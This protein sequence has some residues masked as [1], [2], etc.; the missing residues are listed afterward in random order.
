MVR[1]FALKPYDFAFDLSASDRAKVLLL[2]SAS[3]IRATNDQV[4][5][6]GWKRIIF[7]RLSHFNWSRE[8]QVVRD[9][10]TVTDVMG[11][12]GEPG[13]LVLETHATLEEVRQ[14]VPNL[15]CDRPWAIIHA[16]TRWAYKQWLPERWAEV[17][18]ALAERYGMRV[19]FSCGPDPR[20]VAHVR[21]ILQHSHGLHHS[22]EGQLSLREQARLTRAAKLL[23]CVDT[24]AAHMGAAVQTPTV[25]L[26]AKAK[27][28]AWGPWRCPSVCL[29][30]DCSCRRLGHMA[31]TRDQPYKCVAGI[32]T[33]AVLSAA[34]QLL[35][36]PETTSTFAARV[37]HEA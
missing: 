9:F 15:T 17:A 20:E 23:L 3:R 36:Q 7:N 6:L 1:E 35:R 27:P 12:T 4:Y 11:Q 10:R 21:K 13:P 5:P 37:A 34:E 32:P 24:L 22:T 2:I 16:T 30:G 28:E 33:E 31:C 29:T 19:I 8:H 26:F 25:V 14:K 18:D